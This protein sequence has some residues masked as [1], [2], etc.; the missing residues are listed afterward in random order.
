MSMYLRK[1]SL[2]RAHGKRL[3]EGQALQRVRRLRAVPTFNP[4]NVP[5]PQAGPSRL[6][7]LTNMVR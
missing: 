3:S 1:E 5:D 7:Q 6:L 2:L 4:Q